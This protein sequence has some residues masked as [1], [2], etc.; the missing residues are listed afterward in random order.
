MKIAVKTTRVITI[1]MSQEDAAKIAEES[2]SLKL[3][4]TPAVATLLH[5]IGLA[6]T[7]YYD[8]DVDD[9]EVSEED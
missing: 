7:G 4:R 8:G 1:S 2:P 5:D 6:S 3:L 9:E